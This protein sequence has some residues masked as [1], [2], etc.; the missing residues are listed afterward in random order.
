MTDATS[1]PS[2]T[3]VLIVGAGPSGLAAALSLLHRGFKDFVIVDA[4]EQGE[5]TS[6]A[7]VIH[8]ATLEVRQCI[9]TLG[10]DTYCFV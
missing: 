3:T 8:A 5:N 6:R 9:T 1:I 4:V 7:L 2:S 10:H